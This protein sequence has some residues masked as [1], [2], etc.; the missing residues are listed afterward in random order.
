MTFSEEGPGNLPRQMI[1]HRQRALGL[2]PA[3][4]IIR[5]R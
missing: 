2:T 1:E 4:P 5:D 3:S